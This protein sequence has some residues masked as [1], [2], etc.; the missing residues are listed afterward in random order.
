M[1]ILKVV[2]RCLTGWLSPLSLWGGILLLLLLLLLLCCCSCSCLPVAPGLLLLLLLLVPL[3]VLL[4]LLLSLAPALALAPKPPNPTKR[5]TI[6]E[7]ATHCTT[8]K[9]VTRCDMLTKA[10]GVLD[11]GTE[12]GRFGTIV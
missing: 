2:L 8:T 7:A 4:Q 11:L 1:E 10:Y 5:A 6:T 12:S 3:L 9:P